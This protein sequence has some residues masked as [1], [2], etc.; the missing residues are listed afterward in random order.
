MVVEAA[1][2]AVCTSAGIGS[3]MEEGIG[4]SEVVAVGFDIVTPFDMGL[5]IRGINDL[6]GGWHFCGTRTCWEIGDERRKLG[7]RGCWHVRL[8][9]V[10]IN[11][12]LCAFEK[13]KKSREWSE[14]RRL[15]KFPLD[16]GRVIKW[17]WISNQSST[18]LPW[19]LFFCLYTT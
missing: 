14:A 2:V 1:R 10:V 5:E 16:Y 4:D 3:F 12:F 6:L 13:E 15:V 9:L 17:I 7:R 18:T 19:T 8:I 11:Q